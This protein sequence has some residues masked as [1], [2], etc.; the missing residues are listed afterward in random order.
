MLVLLFLGTT[1]SCAVS[2]SN[3]NKMNRVEKYWYVRGLYDGLVFYEY[4]IA[5]YRGEKPRQSPMFFPWQYYP[6][7]DYELIRQIDQ[8]YKDPRNVNIPVESA[9]GVIRMEKEG[10]SK[11][12]R[13]KEVQDIRAFCDKIIK[14]RYGK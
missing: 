6:L 8:F 10:K 13:E 11:E 7:K 14:E 9:L 4:T 3:W 2:G 1:L 5:G 12:E